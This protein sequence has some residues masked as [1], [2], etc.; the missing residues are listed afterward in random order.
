MTLD[1]NR[2]NLTIMGVPFK[3]PSTFQSV[4]YVVSSSMIEGWQPTPEDIL[5]LRSFAEDIGV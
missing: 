2:D 4:W 1:I 3:S 5:E